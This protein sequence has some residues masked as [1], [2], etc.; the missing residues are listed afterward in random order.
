VFIVERAAGSGWVKKDEEDYRASSI[1]RG[2]TVAPAPTFW[3]G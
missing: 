2:N 3:H 1:A